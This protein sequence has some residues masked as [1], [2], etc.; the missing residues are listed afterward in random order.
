MLTTEGRVV[1]QSRRRVR[2][3]VLV[4]G[5][6]LVAALGALMYIGLRSAAMYYLSV[7][8]LLDRGETAYGQQIRLG[9][10]VIPGSIQ[11]E[12]A[13]STH[14]FVVMSK[15]N[16]TGRTIPVVY[17]GVV[18]D[19]FQEDAEVVLEGGLTPEGVFEAETLLAKCPS[20]YES[21][22]EEKP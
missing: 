7:D 11:H 9:G 17:Q 8:E 12:P 1:P 6:V 15:T 21:K 13:T 18:P 20:K 10:K 22:A 14:R 3:Q 4:A 5:L 16:T 2:R 19:T